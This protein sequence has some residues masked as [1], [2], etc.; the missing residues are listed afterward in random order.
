MFSGETLF[1]FSVYTNSQNNM[2]P[3]L[4]HKVILLAVEDG[5]WYAVS[6][7]KITGPTLFC[8]HEFTSTCYT[9]SDTI[10][11]KHLFHREK[12]FGP[13]PSLSLSSSHQEDTATANTANNSMHFDVYWLFTSSSNI[14]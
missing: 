9:H 10:F 7:N 2:F 12:P 5:E 11:W 14:F 13:P 4:I 8:S 6:A 1:Q 3:A